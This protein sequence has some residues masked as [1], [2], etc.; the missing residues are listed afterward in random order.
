MK[1]QHKIDTCEFFPGND[2]LKQR[3]LAS[4]CPVSYKLSWRL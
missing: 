4:K 1:M 2:P 3:D